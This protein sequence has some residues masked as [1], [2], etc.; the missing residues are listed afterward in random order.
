MYAVI[1][2]SQEEIEKRGSLFEAA[3]GH[4]RADI[5]RLSG[6]SHAIVTLRGCRDIKAVY[7]IDKCY[8]STR[9]DG[10]CVFAGDIDEQLNRALVGKTM[11][12]DLFK[13]GKNYPVLYVEE[14]NLLQV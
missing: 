13:K 9:V 12:K 11:N 3:R 5:D 8:P 2:T 7:R 1:K 6:C 10:R 14:S 4:W